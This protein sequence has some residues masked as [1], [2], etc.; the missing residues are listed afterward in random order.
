MR[1]LVFSLCIGLVI[2][3]GCSK[4]TPNISSTNTTAVNS[5]IR[6]SMPN[7]NIA[8]SDSSKNT[9]DSLYAIYYNGVSDSALTGGS[10]LYAL[11]IAGYRSKDTSNIALIIEGYSAI[12]NGKYDFVNSEALNN[13]NGLSQPKFFGLAYTISNRLGYGFI[14]NIQTTGYTQITNFDLTNKIIE[15]TFEQDNCA[16]YDGNNNILTKGFN[17]T[18]GTF[19]TKVLVINQADYDSKYKNMSIHSIQMPKLSALVNKF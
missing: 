15:G 3:S 4:E 5:Y 16:K 10:K 18:N 7:Q 19:K 11:A 1:K 13:S 8:F 14:D 6:F 2:L 9:A 17:M 12:T